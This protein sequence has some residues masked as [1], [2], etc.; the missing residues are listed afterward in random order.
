MC[1][2]SMFATRVDRWVDDALSQY[3][4]VQREQICKLEHRHWCV[5]NDL[6][7]KLYRLNVSSFRRVLLK[8]YFVVNEFLFLI[9]HKV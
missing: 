5:Y 4:Y 2:R 9:N 3:V 1:G 8:M 7:F 6:L